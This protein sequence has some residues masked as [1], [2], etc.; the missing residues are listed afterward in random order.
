MLS[1][2][3]ANYEKK[4][5]MRSFAGL[6][7]VHTQNSLTLLQLLPTMKCAFVIRHALNSLGL[8][9]LSSLCALQPLTM[10]SSPGNL[11]STEQDGPFQQVLPRVMVCAL[12]T[13]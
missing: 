9:C 4:L 8:V 12:N 5:E 2:L 10:S 7:Y 6:R 3:R 13:V 1:A 11:S